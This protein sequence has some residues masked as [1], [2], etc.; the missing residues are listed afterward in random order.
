MTGLIVAV[1]GPGPV[2]ARHGSTA[3]FGGRLRSGHACR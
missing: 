1:R 3:R 2:P